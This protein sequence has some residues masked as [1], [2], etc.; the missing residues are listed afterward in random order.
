M[1]ESFGIFFLS[2][3]SIGL[4]SVSDEEGYTVVTQ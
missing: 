2:I 1:L 3:P 4:S